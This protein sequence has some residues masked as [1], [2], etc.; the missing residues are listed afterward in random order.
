MGATTRFR[1]QCGYEAL[2]ESRSGY[3]LIA[4]YHLHSGPPGWGAQAHRM[5]R[6]TQPSEVVVAAPRE[7]ATVA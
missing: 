6:V 7:M 3:D 1:C 4:V 5:E 2:E